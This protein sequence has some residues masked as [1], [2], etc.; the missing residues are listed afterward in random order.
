M[1]ALITGAAGFIGS[2]LTDTLLQRGDTVIG[3]DNFDSFYERKHKEHNLKSALTDT[4]FKFI[5]GDIR[6]PAEVKNAFELNPEVVIHLAAKAGVRPSI[7][8]PT[9]YQDVNINGTVNILEAMR[10]SKCRKLIF[11]SSSSVYGNNKK[12]PFS[13]SDPVDHPISPYAATKKA[14]ELLCHTYHHLFD[15][16]I[17]CM[18]FFTVY[19]P[20]QR[21]DLA[22]RKFTRLMSEGKQLKMFGDGSTSRDYTYI[23]DILQGITSSIDRCSGFEIFNLGESK[24]VLL[25]DLISCIAKNLGITP[26]IKVEPM[27]PGDVNQTY[28]DIDKARQMLDYSPVTDIDCGI[29]EFVKWFREND[30]L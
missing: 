3:L 24:P 20:R 1:K 30:L 17:F 19:G 7:E 10:N 8:D 5:E 2:S 23:K 18:R 27:Q 14:G 25:R 9:I 6:N 4:N 13:E 22:I 26:D 21:P 15:I 11:A 16:N 28:A 12:V 29:N